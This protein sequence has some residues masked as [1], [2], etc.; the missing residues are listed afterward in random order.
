MAG[1]DLGINKSASDGSDR[2]PFTE[3]LPDMLTR[4]SS[5]RDDMMRRHAKE[6]SDMMQRNPK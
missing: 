6:L 1:L 3:A 5:E 4:H 2:V